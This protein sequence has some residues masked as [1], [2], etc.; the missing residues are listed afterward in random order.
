MNEGDNLQSQRCPTD[1]LGVP[2]RGRDV[3]VCVCVCVYVCNELPMDPI[4]NKA[5]CADGG[6]VWVEKGEI[7]G[8]KVGLSQR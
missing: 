2:K 8:W 3:S 1:V 6:Q 4:R 7:W 5:K